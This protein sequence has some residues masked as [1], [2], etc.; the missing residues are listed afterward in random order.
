MFFWISSGV[1]ELSSMRS[2]V[3]MGRF[4]L[5]NSNYMDNNY[6]LSCGQYTK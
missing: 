6:A 4:N 5:P 2:R 3:S 1:D